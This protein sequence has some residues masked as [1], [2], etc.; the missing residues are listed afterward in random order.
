MA[1]KVLLA[2]VIALQFV[3][4]PWF[5]KA[6]WPE[7]NKKSL[8]LK[9]VCAALFLFTG[10][11]AQKISANTTPY[12]FWMTLGLVFG[13]IGDFFLHAGSKMGYYIAGVMAFLTGHCCFITAFNGASEKLLPGPGFFEPGEI[14]AFAGLV[15]AMIIFVIKK[16]LRLGPILIPTFVY[17]SVLITMMIKGCSLGLRAFL[18]PAYGVA[19]LLPATGAFLFFVSDVLWANV[20]FNNNK[21]N[22]PMKNANIITYFAGQV[23]L[24]CS[25][26][27]I[28]PA[29][30][31][32]ALPRKRPLPG[33]LYIKAGVKAPLLRRVNANPNHWL[34]ADFVHRRERVNNLAADGDFQMQMVTVGVFNRDFAEF[35]DGPKLL[36]I[37][38]F[39]GDAVFKKAAVFRDKAVAVVNLD[40]GAPHRVIKNTLDG[41]VL[42]GEHLIAFRAGKIHPVVYAPITHGFGLDHLTVAVILENVRAQRQSVVAFKRRVVVRLGDL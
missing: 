22:R 12:A 5:L 27:V 10:I 14:I 2:L 11:L 19:A 7:K 31:K 33:Q 3:F 34:S 17:A 18:S 8:A 24:A 36:D 15:L 13:F 21:Q 35:A 25:M 32:N 30:I 20:N 29:Y 23:L 6:M 4:V 16:K 37:A 1:L 41:A 26:L 39:G 42:N 9:M 28:I 38:A 40:D